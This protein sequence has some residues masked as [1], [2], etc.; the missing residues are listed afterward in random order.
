[1]ARKILLADDSVT[2]QNM[3]RKILAD[4][5]YDVVTVNNGSAALKRITEIKPDLIVLDVYMPGY[6]GLEVCQRL[7][8]TA[9]TA[10]IPVLLTVGKLEPFKPEEARRVRADGHIVKPFEASE[11]LTAITRLE[12]RMVPQSEA[13]FSTS[14]SGLERFGGEER[15]RK[16]ESG[17]ETDTGWKSRLRFPSKKK[18]EE[19]EP[20]PEEVA[21]AATFRDFRKKK[22][23]PGNG[24]SFTVKEPAPPG[25]EPGLVPDI[26]RDITPDELDALSAVAAK[27]DGLVP[28]AEDIAPLA[29]KTGPTAAAEVAAV[30][31]AAAKMEAAKAQAVQPETAR[32]ETT[33]PELEL[34]APAAVVAAAAGVG[35]PAPAVEGK[36][37]ESKTIESKNEV[38]IPVEQLEP[39]SDAAPIVADST[40]EK[41]KVETDRPSNSEIQ[42]PDLECPEASP[43]TVAVNP[44]SLAQGPAP[45]EQDAVPEKKDQRIEGKPPEAVAKVVTSEVST[46]AETAVAQDQESKVEESAKVPESKTQELAAEAFKAEELKAAELKAKESETEKIAQLAPNAANKPAEAEEPVPTDEELAEALRLLTPATVYTDIAA[47]PSHGTLVA[48]GQLLAEEVARDA[49]AG[50]R[51]VA[52]PVALS[53]EEAAISLEAEMFRTFATTYTATSTATPAPIAARGSTR[54]TGVSAIT[55]AVENRLAEAGMVAD[56]RAVAEQ[57]AERDVESRLMGTSA[58][59]A[60]G[61]TTKTASNA[62]SPVVEAIVSEIS[63]RATIPPD[64]SVTEK[65]EVVQKGSSAK[66]AEEAPPEEVATATFADAVGRGNENE[67]TP[68]AQPSAELVSAVT[69]MAAPVTS[70]E[71]RVEEENHDSSS[72]SGSEES[73]GKDG[74]SGTWHQIRTAPAGAA[75]NTNLVEAAKQAEASAEESPKAMA[76]AAAEGSVSTSTTDASTIASIVDSVMADLRPKIVEEIAKKLSGK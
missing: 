70:E 17:G 1:L 14:V 9:E 55:A 51:W 12:D 19:P 24:P 61:E 15:G 68:A 56:A 71:N 28:E 57:Q 62:V 25:Q 66:V 2:A 37:V 45:V 53:P 30:Q 23:K 41:H 5:G 59:A 6:S 35:F 40:P 64:E 16:A 60:P 34:P 44:A 65:P 3:G 74:K 11:L 10:H 18:K 63:A 4:A 7:K 8:D 36:S 13:R 43:V 46:P 52:E 20:E 27:L 54:I 67:D 58:V 48:A 69:A 22:G 42:P 49:A 73:M 26:P 33:K 50:P 29:A 47:L 31:T 21:E 76:A 75:A 72:D 39:A 32:P 38:E